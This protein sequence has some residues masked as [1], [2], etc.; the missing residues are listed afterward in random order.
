ME[1]WLEGLRVLV[2]VMCLFRE[3]ETKFYLLKNYLEG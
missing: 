2:A 3:G 1:R